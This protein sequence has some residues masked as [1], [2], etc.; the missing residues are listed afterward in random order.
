MKVTLITVTYNSA[1]YLQNCIQSVT[2]QDYPDIEYIVID[3]GSTDETISIIEQNQ[4]CI[5]KWK[6]ENDNGMYDAINK[7]MK[8]ATGDVI[9]ILN[10]D[11]VLASKDVI[12]KIAA[13]F[14]DQNV[15]SVF[16]DLLYVDADDISKIHRSWKGMAYNR[17]LF[18]VGWMPA[19]PTFYV[20]REIVEQ[21]G[22]YETHFFSASDFEL[23][24]RYLYKHRVSSY[25][26]PE[27][28]VKMRKGGMSNGSFKKR[29]RANRRDYLALKRNEV[30]FALMVSVIKP[31][32]K[33]PQYIKFLHPAKQ[34][35]IRT[36]L[37]PA[38]A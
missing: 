1:R 33:L 17:N 5:A 30:P 37:S 19:H 16:G 28:I 3:G 14:K 35:E 10:S 15:D 9:G 7:G 32:R 26:L 4:H 24:T 13:C 2:N 23:M 6:S 27:L 31:L 18:K 36:S 11:D 38:T 22:G 29:I 21:L 34:E 12:S 8:L 20:R 25:Y